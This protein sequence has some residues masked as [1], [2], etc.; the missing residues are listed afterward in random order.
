MRTPNAPIALLACGALARDVVEV[1]RRCGWPVD[2]YG[3]A[4]LHHLAPP[5]IVADVDAKLAELSTRYARI[6][7]VY[8]DCGTNGKLDEVLARYPAVRPAGVHCYAWFAEADYERLVSEQIG[9]FFLTDWLVRNWSSA[10]TR[11]LG[12]DRFPWLKET[13]FRHMTRLL[14]LRQRPDPTLESAARAIAVELSLPL[15]I[16]DTGTGPLERVLDALV[17]TALDD[18]ADHASALPDAPG[19]GVDDADAALAP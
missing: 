19:G 7:V 14:Y 17:R 1:V 8:G 6:V 15:E 9:T 12:L 18:A 13:Y 5:R 3:I 2:V 10:V 16:R 4:A 11:G